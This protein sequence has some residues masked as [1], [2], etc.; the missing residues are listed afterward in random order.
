MRLV[1]QLSEV[2]MKFLLVHFIVV[3]LIIFTVLLLKGMKADADTTRF[4]SCEQLHDK[5]GPL[6][7]DSGYYNITPQDEVKEVYCRNN[8]TGCDGVGWTRVAKVD[9][10]STTYNC[11]DSNMTYTE[12]KG[13]PM[14]TRSR[15]EL[16]GCFS[17]NFS[18]FRVPY[19]KV[20]GRARGYQYGFT[21][22]FHSYQYAGQ[23]TLEH[24]Y[25]SGLSVTRGAKGS[26]K[27]IWTF[28]AGFSQAYGYAT[29]NCPCAL[30]PGPDPPPFVG[31]NYFC[32]SG[33]PNNTYRRNYLDHK[34][35]NSL[36]NS[37]GC[38][39]KSKIHCCK[40]RDP[41][42]ITNVGN[43]EEGEQVTTDDIEVRMCHWPRYTQIEDIGVDELEIYI[44]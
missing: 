5:Y 7:P 4:K 10:N 3:P 26:R 40:H 19:N 17:V 43:G 39:T 31:D 22:A 12:V 25:V 41:W 33:N 16:N 18:T 34:Q 44:Y 28:A 30:Y 11:S 2:E 37:N 42:F 13:T 20:C 6:L 23:N 36:W 9:A 15:P 38:G 24:S 1:L 29:V 8:I 32:D 27:H 14:C 21:R 35:T